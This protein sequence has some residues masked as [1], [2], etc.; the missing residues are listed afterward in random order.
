MAVSAFPSTAAPAALRTLGALHLAGS[1]VTRPKPL[2]LLAYLAHEGP[3][4]R[5]RLARLFFVSSRDPRDALS[6][7]LRRLGRLVDRPTER[8]GRLR[9]SVTTDALEFQRHAVAAEPQVALDR[10][11]GAFLQGSAVGCGVELEEWVVSTRERLGSIARNLHLELALSELGRKRTEAA[12]HQMKAAV[13]LTEAFALEPEP[14]AQV[15]QRFDETGRPVPEGWWRAMAALGFD[16]PRR[17]LGPR[18][19]RTVA[20]GRTTA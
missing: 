6:T 2:L 4:D 8:D 5:E 10:Y 14:A 12:W 3:T 7:T 19:D 9:T 1:P 20:R 16:P 11:G 18:V 13:D 17:A 15:L